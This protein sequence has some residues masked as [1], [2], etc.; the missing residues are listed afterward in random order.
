MHITRPIIGLAAAATLALGVALVAPDSASALTSAT[1]GREAD[2]FIAAMHQ[3]GAEAATTRQLFALD[4]QQSVQDI[5]RIV[6]SGLPATVL[7]DADTGET[8]AAIAKARALSLVGPGCSAS[9]LCM[10]TGSIPYGFTG[11][12]ARTG[13]WKSIRTVKAGDRRSA[14]NWNGLQNTY[15][16]GVTV[17]LTKP[18]TVTKIQRW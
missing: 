18:V 13:S 8:V 10:S 16:K 7:V 17:N 11:T 3:T 4:G 14:F 6:E 15:A 1:T 5:D 2:E 12:G 9:S